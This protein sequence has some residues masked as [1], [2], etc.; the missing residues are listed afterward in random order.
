MKITRTVSGRMADG[1]EDT[2]T[3]EVEI[4]L[5]DNA[6]V[7]AAA[8]QA[9]Q[10]DIADAL[11]MPFT[12]VPVEGGMS[13]Y[14][15][16]APKFFFGKPEATAAPKTVAAA[17]VAAPRAAA[18]KAAAG[19][20]TNRGGFGG[21][22]GF[23]PRQPNYSPDEA[24]LLVALANEQPDLFFFNLDSANPSIVPKYGALEALG[25]EREEKPR[26]LYISAIEKLQGEE[27]DAFL[28]NLANG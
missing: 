26:R 24:L 17:P 15:F 11:L 13:R 19:R 1:V 20:P 9:A 2:V 3:V 22:S 21:G 16:A 10:L 23:T 6:E 28:S 14:T 4:T 7:N 25:W 12:E 5:G 8:I 18:P 27:A